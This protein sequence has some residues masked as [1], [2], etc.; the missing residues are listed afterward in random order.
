MNTSSARE[1]ILGRLRTAPSAPGAVPPGLTFGA[2]GTPTPP[3]GLTFGADVPSLSIEAGIDH[4][5]RGSELFHAEVL[6]ARQAGWR[7]ALADVCAVKGIRRLMLPPGAALELASW[8]DGPRLERF[9]RPIENF[10]RALFDEIDAGLTFA[11]GA[12]AD[13]GT[14]FHADPRGTPRTLSLVPPIHI[15]VLDVNR[16]L[17]SLAAAVASE[18]WQAA[19]PTNLVFITGPSKTADIQQVLAYGAHGPKEL[20]VLL[21]DGTVGASA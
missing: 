21:V 8:P 10:K 9:D 6:D 16:I 1:R 14:L 4:F 18:G 20:V 2:G 17:P 5:R 13:T 19:M 7:Q 3:P 12:L 15:C 11:D